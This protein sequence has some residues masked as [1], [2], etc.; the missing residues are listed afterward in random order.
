M[1]GSAGRLTIEGEL[2]ILT[3]ERWLP[4][5][6][7][8]VWAAITD[9]AERARWM[10]VTTIDARE[11]GQITMIPD[12]PPFAAD[13]KRM[14]GDITVWDPPHIFEHVWKQRILETPSV[15]RYELN[16]DDSNP[17]GTRLRFTHRG[18]GV[19]NAGGFRPGT[20]AYLDRLVAYL[21]GEPVPDWSTRYQEVA[22]SI[23]SQKE[24]THRR[25][26]DA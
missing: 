18:L 11:G 24:S 6:I 26:D 8:S 3:F 10:G 16:P 5:P 2:A 15:V 13:N 20:H 1:T 25:N 14:T 7:E 19:R 4:Y 9:P 23:Y 17:P 21:A 12:G 22:T